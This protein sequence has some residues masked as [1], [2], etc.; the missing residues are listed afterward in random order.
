M[1]KKKKRKASSGRVIEHDAAFL[2]KLNK[3]QPPPRII[4]DISLQLW[5][6]AAEEESRNPL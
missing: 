4:D 6:L 5:K 1:A 2:H 3:Q